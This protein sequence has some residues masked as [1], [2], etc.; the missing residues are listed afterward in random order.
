MAI[1]TQAL[2]SI[3]EQLLGTA[4]ALSVEQI[5]LSKK[6]LTTAIGPLSF[7][8]DQ[9]LKAAQIFATNYNSLAIHAKN[10]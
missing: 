8:T 1:E 5:A 2:T 9:V 7:S 3:Q 10:A 6:I 4:M